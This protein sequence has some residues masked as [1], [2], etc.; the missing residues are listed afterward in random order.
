MASS[1]SH[2][3]LLCNEW[4]TLTPPTF[5]PVFTSPMLKLLGKFQL[6]LHHEEVSWQVP[7][8]GDQGPP[9]TYA[10]WFSLG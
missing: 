4:Q 1:S 3:T 7:V 5:G 6:L 10:A 8:K 9:A 2:D